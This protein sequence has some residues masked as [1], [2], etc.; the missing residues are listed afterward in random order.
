MH[1]P[2]RARKEQAIDTYV[3]LDSPVLNFNDRVMYG[4]KS[5]AYFLKM[6]KSWWSKTASESVSHTSVAFK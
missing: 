5:I 4:G 2:L 6:G 1:Q 3:G